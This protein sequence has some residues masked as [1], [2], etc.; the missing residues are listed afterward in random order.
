MDEGMD[1]G[2]ILL[3]REVQIGNDDDAE[4]ML[5]RLS[6]IG[7][8]M[9]VETLSLLC[10]EKL[11]PVKQDESEVIYA[12]MLHKS[13]G[14]IEW[15]KPTEDIR[16]LIRG[17]TPWPGTFTKLGDKTLKIYKAN[18]YEGRGRPGEI[19]ESGK[20]SMI[21]ATG[22]TAL[23]I[24]ELQI[25]GGKRLDIKSFLSGHHIEKGAILRS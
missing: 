20:N 24:L 10:R 11:K 16:N 2:D 12:P 15:K 7:A 13:D 6:H 22:D 14:E 4:T 5:E 18:I 9:L 3:V 1:S 25:E 19:I 23:E 8:E 21:V 17:L